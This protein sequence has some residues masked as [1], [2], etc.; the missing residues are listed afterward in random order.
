MTNA[1]RAR[2][3]ADT[4]RA[5]AADMPDEHM[6]TVTAGT[7]RALAMLLDLVADELETE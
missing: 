3:V 4:C 7:L 1:E 2:A 5:D 6:M